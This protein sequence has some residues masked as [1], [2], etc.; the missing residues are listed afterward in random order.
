MVPRH[1]QEGQEYV[2][3]GV[4]DA[5][6]AGGFEK[7]DLV[8]LRRSSG[9]VHPT[10]N[11]ATPAA[12]QASTLPST[13]HS[14]WTHREAD[15]VRRADSWVASCT[16]RDTDW[17]APASFAAGELKFGSIEV[18]LPPSASSTSAGPQ[19]IVRVSLHRRKRARAHTHTAP[20]L[21]AL[22]LHSYCNCRAP[23]RVGP[24]CAR[25]ARILCSCRWSSV[26]L[27]AGVG[28][29]AHAFFC[30]GGVTVWAQAE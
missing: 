3:G 25:V 1:W 26:C 7:G 9:N 14:C 30:A 22:A 28:A 11:L 8:V 29:R 6:G 12:H 24:V 20:P 18:L 17:Y 13:L 16:W 5:Q 23:C 21:P 15:P 19:C 2:M 4:R 10:F 27:R